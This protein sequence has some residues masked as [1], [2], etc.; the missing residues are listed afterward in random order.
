MR[1]FALFRFQPRHP[2]DHIRHP[3][4]RA[5]DSHPDQ[6]RIGSFYIARTV[7]RP[8]PPCGCVNAHQ[9]WLRHNGRSRP[10]FCP[11]SGHHLSVY[12]I[13]IARAS[14]ICPSLQRNLNFNLLLVNSSAKQVPPFR[15]S[16]ASMSPMDY[17]LLAARAH[18][19]QPDPFFDRLYRVA[20]QLC[21]RS[22][23]HRAPIPGLRITN[24][25]HVNFGPPSQLHMRGV[26]C[27]HSALGTTKRDRVT[28]N[29]THAI[30]RN[31]SGA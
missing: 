5:V 25:R 22:Q 10:R 12:R 16:I 3:P 19:G 24:Q 14:R 6:L 21:S 23:C 20:C 27:R 18:A 11:Q 13:A 15:I 28:P 17:F 9:H 2:L 8:V 29:L 4:A 26:G 30:P 31:D 1:P 7:I